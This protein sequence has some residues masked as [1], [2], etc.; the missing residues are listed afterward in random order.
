[1]PGSLPLY[2]ADVR[3]EVIYSWTTSSVPGVC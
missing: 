2:D 1:M 3:N